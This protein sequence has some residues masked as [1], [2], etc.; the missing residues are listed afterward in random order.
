MV[1]PMMKESNWN[2]WALQNILLLFLS[3]HDEQFFACLFTGVE[4]MYTCCI[5]A[6]IHSRCLKFKGVEKQKVGSWMIEE[7]KKRNGLKYVV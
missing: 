4:S 5:K 1:V 3:T 6:N 2:D 7:E